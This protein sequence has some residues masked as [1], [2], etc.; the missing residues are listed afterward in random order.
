MAKIKRSPVVKGGK[1]P[2]IFLRYL[3]LI[4]V[5]FPGLWLF[6]TIFTPLTV[7]PVHFILGLFYNSIMLTSATFLVNDVPIELIKACI[8]GSAY[9]LLLIFNLSTPGIKIKTRINAIL[10]SFAAFLV[11][12]IIRIIILSSLAVSGSPYLDVTH[13]L[14]WYGLSTFIVVG[15]W[16]AEVKMFKIKEI[17][18][19]SDLK[20]IYKVSH[21]KK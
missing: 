18:L 1:L 17:P 2:T 5:A 19:Y 13:S 11:L 8:A 20:S 7:Y 9:Y 16:F 3:I 6:Y 12:N 21:L 15:I 4:A 14:F 10:F